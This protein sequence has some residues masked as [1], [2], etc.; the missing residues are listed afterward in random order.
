MLQIQ[1]KGSEI[2]QFLSFPHYVS[3]TDAAQ[4]LIC[5]QVKMLTSCVLL[6][7]T[8]PQ[9]LKKRKKEMA[10][11]STDLLTSDGWFNTLPIQCFSKYLQF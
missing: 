6:G 5:Q 2:V 11:K 9:T 4:V 1:S 3:Y 8:L 10:D 7:F